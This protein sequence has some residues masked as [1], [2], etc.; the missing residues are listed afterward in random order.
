VRGHLA[1]TQSCHKAGD[2]TLTARDLRLVAS[3]ELTGNKGHERLTEVFGPLWLIPREPRS[4]MSKVNHSPKRQ[5]G[6]GPHDKPR[7][8]FV[9]LSAD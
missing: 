6:E 5:I 7:H 8:N 2:V 1:I 3:P 9:Y 4:D